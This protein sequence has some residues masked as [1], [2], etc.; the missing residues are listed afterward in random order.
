LAGNHVLLDKRHGQPDTVQC[1]R[2]K[3]GRRHPQLFNTVSPIFLDGP[4]VLLA[5]V[6]HSRDTFGREGRDIPPQWQRAE[7]QVMIDAVPPSAHAQH[8][9]KQRVP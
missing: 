2:M 8:A 7:Q 3:V 1:R 9:A 6:H 4:G 5:R